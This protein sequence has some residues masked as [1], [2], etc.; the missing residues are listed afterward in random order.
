VSGF[1]A[2]HCVLSTYRGALDLDLIPFLLK[3]G[4]AG[5]RKEYTAFVENICDVVPLSVMRLIP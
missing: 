3:N 5:G 2:E 1:C 4:I